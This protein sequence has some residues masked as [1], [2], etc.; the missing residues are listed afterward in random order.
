MYTCRIR[1]LG[2]DWFSCRD[3]RSIIWSVPCLVHHVGRPTLLQNCVAGNLG[4][5]PVHGRARILFLVLAIRISRTASKSSSQA[6]DR[7]ST[8]SSQDFLETYHNRLFLPEA[9]PSFE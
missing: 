8:T 3:E 2:L 5:P 9:R 7:V 4:L 1:L 6:L